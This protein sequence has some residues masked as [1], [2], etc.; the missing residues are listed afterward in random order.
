MEWVGA[1]MASACFAARFSIAFCQPTARRES[2]SGASHAR[3]SH[4]VT[5]V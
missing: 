3:R 2:S 5:T 1:T 4:T